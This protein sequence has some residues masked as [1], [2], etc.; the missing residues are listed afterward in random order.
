[1]VWLM[2]FSWVVFIG[3]G[4][5]I[6][7]IMGSRGTFASLETLDPPAFTAFTQAAHTEPLP[8]PAN[9]LTLR[10]SDHPNVAKQRAVSIWPRTI[11]CPAVL[12]ITTTAIDTHN[13]VIHEC[14]HLREWHDVF[15]GLFLAGGSI[16]IGWLGFPVISM[17]IDYLWPTFH[18]F[19]LPIGYT[20]GL[21]LVSIVLLPRF[22]QWLELRAD[23]YIARYGDVSAQLDDWFLRRNTYQ[24]GFFRSHPSFAV[25]ARALAHVAGMS[26]PAW[27]RADSKS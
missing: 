17:L 26:V 10:F 11:W 20:I 27:A 9:R 16:I 12:S 3:V 6:V 22:S 25:R 1:M 19:V 18:S 2:T 7:F 8:I 4:L 13:L 15:K 5:L 21:I 23:R 24:P 14:G